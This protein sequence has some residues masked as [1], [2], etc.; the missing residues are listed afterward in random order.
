MPFKVIE[1]F[2]SPEERYLLIRSDQK[3]NEA[4]TELICIKHA[5]D[6]LID[7]DPSSVEIEEKK[8]SF[9]ESVKQFT[10]TL[11]VLRA[12][13]SE[14][15]RR[16]AM[17]IQDVRNYLRRFEADRMDLTAITRRADIAL[18]ELQAQP[19]VRDW[20]AHSVP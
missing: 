7:L 17:T 16:V 13:F 15:V 19:Y 3:I 5:A 18:S 6:E 1:K 14:T 20:R 10:K 9:F 2:L 11:S 8:L 12:A 4:H